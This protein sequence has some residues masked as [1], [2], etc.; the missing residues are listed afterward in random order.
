MQNEI[1]QFLS[2]LRDSGRINMFA[3]TPYL[4]SRF[5]LTRREAKAALLDWIESFKKGSKQ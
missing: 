1:N 3:A 4:E 2:D 5:G